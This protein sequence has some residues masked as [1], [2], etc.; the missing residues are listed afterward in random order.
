MYTYVVDVLI[1]TFAIYGFLIFLKEYLLET[2]CYIIMKCIYIAK[3]CEKFIDKN[4][5]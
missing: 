3:L 1:W 4:S 5:A 2:V